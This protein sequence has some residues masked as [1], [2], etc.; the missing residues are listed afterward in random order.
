MGMYV[1]WPAAVRNQG[2]A[3]LCCRAFLRQVRLAVV[4]LV[5]HMYMQDACAVG[6]EMQEENQFG[7]VWWPNLCALCTPC[8]L[9]DMQAAQDGCCLHFA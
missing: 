5:S 6:M 7:A 9:R 4:P 8:P 1:C 3:V 2:L